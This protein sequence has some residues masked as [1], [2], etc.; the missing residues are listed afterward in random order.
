MI[1]TAIGLT[2]ASC[3]A[4]SGDDA[5]NPTPQ[6]EIKVEEKGKEQKKEFRS[7]WHWKI[8][9]MIRFGAKRIRLD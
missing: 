8:I 4:D 5:P 6:T 9:K 3:T 1:L 7:I 2:F